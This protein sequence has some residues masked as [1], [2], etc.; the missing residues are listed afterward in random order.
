MDSE[1]QRFRISGVQKF[2]GSEFL[3]SEIQGFRI[4]GVQKFKAKSASNRVY[5][6]D[7]KVRKYCFLQYFVD[8]KVQRYCF[9]QYFV[10]PKVQTYCFLEYFVDPKVQTHC[11]LQYFVDPKV[12]THCFLQYFVD[13]IQKFKAKSASYRVQKFRGSEIQSQIR[14]LQ[15]KSASYRPNPRVTDQNPR[16]TKISRIS[17]PRISEPLN[18]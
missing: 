18:F 4:S 15:T 8:P 7:P 3:D 2:R 13:P 11:F 5:V 1:I 16:V 6:V 10:D 14:E 17:E 9:L 12:Q